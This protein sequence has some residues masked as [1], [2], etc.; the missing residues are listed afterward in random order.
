MKSEFINGCVQ[1]S[2]LPKLSKKSKT[3]K[4][5]VM[6]EEVSI[7]SQSL[8]V[9]SKKKVVVI[10]KETGGPNHRGIRMKGF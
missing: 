10:K 1:W 8:E 7:D 5:G 4:E 9:V 2:I 6:P 3:M